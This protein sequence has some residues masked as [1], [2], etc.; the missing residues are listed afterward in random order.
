[1]ICGVSDDDLRRARDDSRRYWLH[2]FTGI[3]DIGR[4]VTEYLG[5]PRTARWVITLVIVA[6]I[7]TGPVIGIAIALLD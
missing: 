2:N 1:M 4:V 5:A 6:L 3:P 7:M